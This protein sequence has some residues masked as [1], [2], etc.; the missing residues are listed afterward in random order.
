MNTY[1]VS[2]VRSLMH[3]YVKFKARDI[4]HVRTHVHKYYGRLWCSIYSETEMDSFK[5][6]YTC[7]V[8]NE[9]EPVYLSVTEEDD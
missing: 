8:I 1:Y 6:K 7:K 3:Y 9:D 4:D 2:L 5:L